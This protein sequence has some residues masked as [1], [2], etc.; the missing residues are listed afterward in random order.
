MKCAFADTR[1]RYT[2][3]TPAPARG[4]IQNQKDPTASGVSAE[5]LKRKKL[6]TPQLPLGLRCGATGGF[7][8]SVDVW[9][10]SLDG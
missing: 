9:L 1:I 6:L 7:Q 5:H 3:V 8:Q 2:K 10:S 4:P